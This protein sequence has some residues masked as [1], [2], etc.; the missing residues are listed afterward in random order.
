MDQKKLI[1]NIYHLTPLNQTPD[2]KSHID[3]DLQYSP[4]VTDQVMCSGAGAAGY[5]VW[6]KIH[7]KTGLNVGRHKTSDRLEGTLAQYDH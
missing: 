4:S 5:L 3:E 6:Y 7:D 1:L 2:V